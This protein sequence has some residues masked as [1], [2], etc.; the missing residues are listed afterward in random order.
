MSC[1][2]VALVAGS[3]VI[4]SC[5]DPNA[6]D[7]QFKCSAPDDKCP[8]DTSCNAGFCRTENFTGTCSDGVA[9]S[10]IDS[11]TSTCSPVPAGCMLVAADTVQCLAV[12]PTTG[13]YSAGSTEC[14]L[15]G[16]GYHLAVLDTKAK[17]Y[18]AAAALSG[19]GSGTV[20]GSSTIHWIGLER[21]TGVWTWVT[22]GTV[23]DGDPLWT[24][25]GGHGGSAAN[26]D[27]A[28]DPTDGSGTY[29]SDGVGQ[30][31]PSICT[32]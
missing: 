24:T 3:A 32:K 31:H 6:T 23:P 22:G 7:C 4:G 19:S 5:Y 12:C 13:T 29:Y 18:A 15:G 1:T 27:G 11:P 16:T 8:S 26:N 25:M 14:M 30:L 20:A 2:V 10:G 28:I 21:A 9:D 17:L